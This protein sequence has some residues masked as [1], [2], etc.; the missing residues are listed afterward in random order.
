[1][2]FISKPRLALEVQHLLRAVVH[3]DE[4]VARVVLRHLLAVLRRHLE[5]E[6]ARAGVGRG[7]AHRTVA[8]SPSAGS[9][10]S[11]VLDDAPVVLDVERHGLAAV[12]G[13]RQ[14]DV[15]DERG[16][17]EHAAR[18]LDARDLH[19]LREVLLADADGED[20][21]RPRLQAGERLVDAPRRRCRRRR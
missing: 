19:V 7:E 8:D 9:V 20:R 16:A 13:L 1:M 21:D 5:P 17:L 2:N 4:R 12:A 15:D 14:H 10:T 18:R 6:R 3:L 11:C